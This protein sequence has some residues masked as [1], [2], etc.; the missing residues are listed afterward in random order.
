MSTDSEDLARVLDLL[1]PGRVDPTATAA[2]A[3]RV[4]DGP[5]P[6]HA[7]AEDAISPEAAQ[8]LLRSRRMV[9]VR[10]VLEASRGEALAFLARWRP[11]MPDVREAVTTHLD[12]LAEAMAEVETAERG[13][14]NPDGECT[15][16]CHAGILTPDLPAPRSPARTVPA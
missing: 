13:C 12:L 6:P 1:R 2:L 16:P 4:V 9:A 10:T 8:A 14:G 5:V 15:D 11:G 3:A 7:L